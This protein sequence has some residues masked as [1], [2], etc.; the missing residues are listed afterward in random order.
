M[1]PTNILV[2]KLKTYIYVFFERFQLSFING[3]IDSAIYH[4]LQ[5][6]IKHEFRVSGDFSHV[7][8][9]NDNHL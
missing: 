5:F 6:N 2:L 4:D 3:R 7:I 9:V 8:V 1:I